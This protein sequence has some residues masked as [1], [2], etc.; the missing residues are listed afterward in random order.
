MEKHRFGYITGYEVRDPNGRIVS[1]GEDFHDVGIEGKI[2]M[3]LKNKHG[4]VICEDE[5]PM[6]SYTIGMLTEFVNGK[7]VG[8]RNGGFQVLPQMLGFKAAPTFVQQIGCIA[9]FMSYPTNALASS[10]IQSVTAPM[11]LKSLT[12]ESS[13]IRAVLEVQRSI[14]S[15]SGTVKEIALWSE[16]NIML[17]RD[18]VSDLAF[19]VGTFLTIQWTLDFPI[20]ATKTITKN[21]IKNFL[22]NLADEP[23]QDFKQ[24]D[25]TEATGVQSVTGATFTK[26]ANM[27]GA[28]NTDD[29][30]IVIGTSAATPTWT[31]Y[32]LGNQIEHGTGSGQMQYAAMSAPS[33]VPT[34]HPT[35]GKADVSYHREFA[36]NSGAAIT[37]KEAGII[38]KTAS[39]SEGVNTA[40]SYLVARWLTQDVYVANGNTLRI[41]FKPR[42]S[43]TAEIHSGLSGVI[44]VTDALRQTYP[45][46]RNIS[47]IQQTSVSGKTWPQALEYARNLTLGGFT[48]WR[49]PRATG[50]T[51]D[52]TVNNELYG[53][54]RARNALSPTIPTDNNYYWS[55]TEKDASDAWLVGFNSSSSVISIGK[56]NA[57]Y[58][59]C[60]R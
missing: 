25:G 55:A 8:L 33:N 12:E 52:Q 38:A 27:T 45:E 10:S 17:A 20:V 22:Q 47:M 15:G 58:V 19:Q 34:I 42:V 50:N 2:R 37:I 4:D 51:T 28:V 59:R 1:R 21:W 60:V 31:D 6:E 57:R 11:R 18:A 40:G 46:L 41:Y 24:I 5:R 53:M 39:T 29:V 14:T 48:D 26:A 49:L 44:I 36:N 23:F 43:A 9:P 13:S 35:T 56:S 7:R 3:I 16:G 30:G 54:W 32:K